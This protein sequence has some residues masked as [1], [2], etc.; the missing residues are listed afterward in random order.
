MLTLGTRTAE[1]TEEM[2]T[3]SEERA[4]H[5]L[6]HD[7]AE[8]RARTG[9][10]YSPEFGQLI[11]AMV[12]YS[13]SDVAAREFTRTTLQ[14]FSR[15]VELETGVTLGLHETARCAQ[16]IRSMHELGD[17]VGLNGLRVYAKALE[18]QRY[19]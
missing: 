17:T 16:I 2:L 12:T 5:K 7:L 19:R 6:N 11:G 13:D 8:L 9:R 18:S 1:V 10:D 14:E 3:N 15:R 4:K